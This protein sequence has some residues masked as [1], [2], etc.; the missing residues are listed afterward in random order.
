MQPR[1]VIP[2]VKVILKDGKAYKLLSA[3]PKNKNAIIEEVGVDTH[4]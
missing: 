2:I 1:P 4:E 3:V